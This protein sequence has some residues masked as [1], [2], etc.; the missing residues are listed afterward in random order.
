MGH[1]IAQCNQYLEVVKLLHIDEVGLAIDRSSRTN[2][3]SCSYFL[4]YCVS[5]EVEHLNKD[6]FNEKG[7]CCEFGQN[8]FHRHFNA[9]RAE[10]RLIK[11]IITELSCM[12]GVL[13][14][15]AGS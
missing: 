3:C 5:N 7:Y 2:K 13:L 14:I 6:K 9:A 1:H 15:I 10:N 12:V 4:H 8:S 11:D